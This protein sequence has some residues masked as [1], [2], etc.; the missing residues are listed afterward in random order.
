MKIAVIEDNIEIIE[1]IKQK[2]DNSFELNYYQKTDDFVNHA[3]NF[4]LVLI[5]KKFVNKDII[6]KISGYKL[7]I[8]LIN[9]GNLDFD[10]EHIAI[11]L[12]N[13]GI[14]QISDKLKYFEAKIRIKNLIDLEEKT[15]NNIQKLTI[16]SDFLMLKKKQTEEFLK[17]IIKSNYYF[18][19][20]DGIG[21]LEIRDL[22]R[23]IEFDEIKKL[24][25]NVNFKVAVYFV[26][27]KTSSRYLGILANLWK[28]VNFNK[29]KVV[30]WNKQRDAQIVSVLKLCRLDKL[31]PIVDDFDDAKKILKEIK[32]ANV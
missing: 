26:L 27:H 14:D 24:L 29:G 11:V 18:E 3:Q 13:E 25:V 20:Q 21:V 28:E 32:N 8:G 5:D 17:K 16:R 1:R 12:D 6:E 19:Q 10:N 22:I 30:Y 4:D 15:I 23:E 31:M 2:I 9:N 7:E